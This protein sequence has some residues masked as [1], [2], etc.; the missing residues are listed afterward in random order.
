MFKGLFLTLCLKLLVNLSKFSAL[1]LV[2]I[3]IQ[4]GSTTFSANLLIV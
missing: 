4:S 2:L 1:H 3:P